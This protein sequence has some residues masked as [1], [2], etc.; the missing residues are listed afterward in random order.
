M[1]E[2]TNG[3]KRKLLKNRWL[4]I[5]CYKKKY[6]PPEN[7]DFRKLGILQIKCDKCLAIPVMFMEK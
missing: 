2:D 1:T 5:E 4:C 7:F 3:E 6:N